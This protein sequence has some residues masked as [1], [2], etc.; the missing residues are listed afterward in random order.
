[1]LKHVYAY[2]ALQS[3]FFFRF[4]EGNAR[5]RERRAVKRR[6]AKTR[7]AAREDLSVLCLSRLA[8]SVTRVVI[9]AFRA[10]VLLDGLRKKRDL[11]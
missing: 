2:V 5:A 11:S 10:Y 7:A 1:M 3:L 9:C 8:P 6:D 4:S